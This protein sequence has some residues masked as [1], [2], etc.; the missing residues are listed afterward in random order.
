M[1]VKESAER[2]MTHRQSVDCRMKMTTSIFHQDSSLSKRTSYTRYMVTHL[3]PLQQLF[4]H[5]GLHG[6]QMET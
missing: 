2:K 3:Y 4:R 1:E 5:R 6:V